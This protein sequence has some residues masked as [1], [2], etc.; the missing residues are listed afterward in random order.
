[1]SVSKPDKRR[2][3]DGA[4]KAEALR[5]ARE[6]RSTRAAAHQLDISE[7]LL[8]RWQQAQAVAEA[9]SVEHAQDPAYRALRAENQRLERELAILKKHWSSSA[10]R[11]DEHLPFYRAAA[12][13]LP[14]SRV[15]P[16]AGHGPER[17]LC[18]TATAPT[19]SPGPGAGRM[20]D[21]RPACPPLR[22][23]PPTG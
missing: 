17:L 9:G 2:K 15:V 10:A 5:L 23:P 1:M 7:K 6:S 16:G 8:Y 13:P 14:G 12:P 18:L 3:Y 19:N 4:F 21:L 11:P 22:H 20:P